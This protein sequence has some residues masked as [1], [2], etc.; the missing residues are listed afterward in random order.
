MKRLKKFLRFLILAFIILLAAM[1]V[2][3]PISFGSKEEY[4]DR[5][6]RI[7]QVERKR[8]DDEEEELKEIGYS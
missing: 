3:V 8:E 2:G 1:G 4:M 6:V 5:E 7:E